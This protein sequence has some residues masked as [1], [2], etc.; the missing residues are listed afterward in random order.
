MVGVQ[1]PCI[2]DLVNKE[3][4]TTFLEYL[5]DS[6]MDP[7]TSTGPECMGQVRKGYRWAAAGEQRGNFFSG[8]PVN[9]LVPLNLGPTEHFEYACT[10]GEAEPFPMDQGVVIQRDLRFAVHQ[11][12]KHRLDL[13]AKREEWFHAFKELSSRLEEVSKHIRKFT[14]GTIATLTCKLHFALI[15]V[16]V[17]LMGWPHAALVR[18]FLEG[19]SVVGNIQASGIYRPTDKKFSPLSETELKDS[20]K[21]LL[22]LICCRVPKTE[23]AQHIREACEKDRLAGF[24]SGYFSRAQLDEYWGEGQWVPLPTFD[25]EQSSGKHRRID[26]GLMSRHNEASGFEESL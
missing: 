13:K 3:P 17:I 1:F 6:E 24:A 20:S 25:H 2:E 22:G 14:T 15:G 7:G 4:F 16:A 18:S 12:A 8:E 21:D 11:M 9:Q 26:N 10:L 23:D 5:G 19:F